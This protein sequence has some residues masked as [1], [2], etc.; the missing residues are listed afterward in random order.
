M[1]TTKL[2]IGGMSCGHCVAAVAKALEA[3]EGVEVHE[4][5]IGH[6]ELSLENP[7]ASLDDVTHAIERAGYSVLSAQP[8][9]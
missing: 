2:T 5:A 8:T 6:V 1:K 9:T 3:V 4:V 7:A